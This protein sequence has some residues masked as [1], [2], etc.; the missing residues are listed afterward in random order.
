MRKNGKVSVF[1]GIKV[2]GEYEEPEQMQDP[3][4]VTSVSNDTIA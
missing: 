1:E 3:D 4:F 2:I